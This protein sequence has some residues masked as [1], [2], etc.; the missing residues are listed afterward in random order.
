MNNGWRVAVVGA[1]GVYG[2]TLIRVLEARESPVTELRAVASERSVGRNVEFRGDEV[3]VEALAGFDFSKVDFALFALPAELALEYAPI[4]AE[5][6][7]V[8]VDASLA[9]VG[10]PDVPVVAAQVNPEALDGFR[11][12]QIVRSPAPA[13]QGLVVA[14]APIAR[15][16]GLVEV[17]IAGYHAVV[18]AGR[19]AVDELA[20]QC[21]LLLNGRPVPV[22][23]PVFPGRIAFNCIAA[24]G[25]I[26]ADGR[27][28]AERAVE[29]DLRLLLALP[30]LQIG[31]TA[32]W[33]PTFYGDGAAVQLTTGSA[34]SGAALRALLDPV[35][36]LAV[37]PDGLVPTPAGQ[38]ADQADVY[39]GRLRQTAAGD[40]G[41]AFW[42]VADHLRRTAN[43]SVTLVEVLARDHF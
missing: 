23:G 40:R 12:R 20:A 36:G 18:G 37:E 33:V 1:T 28:D 7:C 17:G 21:G 35:E 4:A 29:D 15:A 2:E 5:A 16:A 43:N 14:L 30:D 13:A 32:V 9:F 11:N 26:G 6:G 10:D 31:Y 8:V 41:H 42:V 19:G 22:A 24:T 39:L 3:P 38:G 27:T 25:R 34:V